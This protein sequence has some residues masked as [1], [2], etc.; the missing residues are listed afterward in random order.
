MGHDVSDQHYVKIW[1]ILLVLLVIS[2]CG[3]MLEIKVVTLITAFG[4]AIVKAW[5][6]ASY[7]MHLNIEKKYITY[8]LLL[9]LIMLGV[10]FFGT[11]VDVMKFEGQNWKKPQTKEVKVQ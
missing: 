6:V 1:G 5:I 9:M 8:M 11:A 3:P 4:I 10:F 7:F 2:I